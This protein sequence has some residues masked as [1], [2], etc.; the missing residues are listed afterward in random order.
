[1]GCRATLRWSGTDSE[2]PDR[3]RMPRE[4]HAFPE[5][6]RS[7]SISVDG[8]GAN[9]L[10]CTLPVDRAAQNAA[11]RRAFVTLHCAAA[12]WYH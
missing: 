10:E 4:C 9:N 2:D 6:P 5:S 11:P 3:T 1:M 12:A 8:K 7:S